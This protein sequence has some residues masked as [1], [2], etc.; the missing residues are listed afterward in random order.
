M[1]STVR[2]YANVS[3]R[4]MSSSTK[5]WIYVL[6]ITPPN[7]MPNSRIWKNIHHKDAVHSSSCAATFLFLACLP[8]FLAASSAGILCQ[9]RVMVA[10]SS[11]S[12]CWICISKLCWRRTRGNLEWLWFWPNEADA[13]WWCQM[14][15]EWGFRW[16]AFRDRMTHSSRMPTPVHS[17][18]RDH[19]ILQ[20]PGNR[21]GNHEYFL[22]NYILA[23]A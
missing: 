2:S 7:Y 1:Q 13:W 18:Y 9:L 14:R 3:S 19:E 8:C 16:D 21:D 23:N 11:S 15:N 5:C 4:A 12:R 10:M 6:L 22:R 17:R 20:E